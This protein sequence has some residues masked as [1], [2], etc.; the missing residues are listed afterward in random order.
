MFRS[1]AIRTRLVFPVCVLAS[2][3]VVIGITGLHGMSG[4]NERLKA[5]YENQT[6]PLI[7]L[8]SALDSMH[9]IRVHVLAAAVYAENRDMVEEQLRHIPELDAT[10]GTARSAILALS[11]TPE[12]KATVMRIDDGWNAYVAVRN[13]VIE[14][15]RGGDRDQASAIMKVTGAGEKYNDAVRSLRKLMELKAAATGMQFGLALLEYD[16]VRRATVAVVVAGLLAGFAVAAWIIRS[17][18]RPLRAAVAVAERI[19]GGNLGGA[20]PPA[21]RDE[22]G[23]LLGALA[24]MQ[25]APSPRCPT[26]PRPSASRRT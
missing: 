24:S 1:P 18:T 22:I 14:T 19:A 2:L 10:I 17:I 8:G 9:R 13:R 20:V 7:E 12:E 6:L 11:L 16:A 25:A 3:L 5:V 15:I 21:G 23:Q 4:S 26:L